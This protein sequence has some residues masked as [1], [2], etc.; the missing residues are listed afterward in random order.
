MKKLIDQETCRKMFLPILIGKRYKANCIKFWRECGK[1][2]L[3]HTCEGA[4]ECSYFGE[5]LTDCKAEDAC[6]ISQCSG[7]KQVAQSNVII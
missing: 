5:Q 3:T 6:W 2:E 4:D 7:W 1:W